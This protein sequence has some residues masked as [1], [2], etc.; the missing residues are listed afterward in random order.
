MPLIR[1]EAISNRIRLS[2]EFG[3]LVL[4]FVSEDST[5][6]TLLTTVIDESSP[7]K[8]G[9]GSFGSE[10]EFFTWTDKENSLSSIGVSV[11]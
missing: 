4:A 7:D 8:D 10:D 9:I 11:G 6:D 5:V 1:P 3:R 2:N